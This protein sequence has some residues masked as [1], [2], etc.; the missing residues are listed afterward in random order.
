MSA[1]RSLRALPARTR[2][3]RRLCSYLT[4]DTINPVVV[5][6]Q[7]AVRGELVLRAAAMKAKLKEDPNAFPFSKLVECNIGNPQALQQA[8]LSF[9]REVLSLVV[10][11][12]LL[13]APAATELFAPDA[14]A[15]AK[16]YLAA[17]PSGVGAYSESQ[18]FDLVRQQVADFIEA[19]DGVP[20]RKQDIFLTDGASKGVAFVLRLVLRARKGDGLLVPIPQYPLYSATLALQSA[21]LLGYELDEAAG[22]TLPISLLEEQVAKA[23][24]DGVTPRA[25]AVINPGNPTGNCLPYDN[26]EEVIRFCGREGLV[27]MADEVYQENIWDASLPFHSFKKVLA[28][29]KDAPRVQLASFHSTSKG[30]IGECGLRGGYFE[31]VGFEPEV[32][33]QLLKLVSIGLCSNTLGQIGTGLMVRPPAP[34]EP[35]HA[36]YAEQKGGGRPLIHA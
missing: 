1:L 33:A 24:A 20:A 36:K 35:S 7:Y 34:G 17:I 25:L 16:D 5:E 12:S 3:A 31:L 19:R 15:R 9:N 8:P 18:G 22:W 10:N 13:D 26:M 30:F 2:S 11:R 14:I 28:Q 29:M 6:A 4:V 21:T 23:K 27:L 32:Q